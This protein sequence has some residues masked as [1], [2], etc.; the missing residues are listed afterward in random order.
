MKTRNDFVSNSSKAAV[1]HQ[2][3][4]CDL[5]NRLKTENKRLRAV[6][7][8]ILAINLSFDTDPETSAH[9]CMIAVADALEAYGKGI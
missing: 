1:C 7:K 4:N 6:L 9:R 3:R 2:A 5:L 8:P